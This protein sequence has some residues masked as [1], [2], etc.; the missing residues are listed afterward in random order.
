MELKI[1]KKKVVLKDFITKGDSDWIRE[2]MFKAVEYSNLEKDFTDP[3]I[4]KINPKDFI[5]SELRGIVVWIKSLGETTSWIKHSEIEEKSAKLIEEIQMLPEE[6]WEQL[7][8]FIKPEEELTP[9]DKTTDKKS[10]G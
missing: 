8:G 6:D 4:K 2:I 9:I 1:S 7:V 10:Q 3:N 5:E